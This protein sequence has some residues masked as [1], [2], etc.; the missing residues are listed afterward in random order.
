MS[1]DKNENHYIGTFTILQE[2]LNGELIYN[3][4]KGIIL[5]NVAKR[6]SV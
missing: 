6:L 5:L 2:K 3:K 4:K 1:E